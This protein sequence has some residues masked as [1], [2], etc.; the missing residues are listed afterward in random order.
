MEEDDIAGNAKM[1]TYRDFVLNSTGYQW[2]IESL[3]KQVSLE[4]GF[5][6]LTNASSSRPIHQSIM[7]RLPSGIISVHQV[8]E[9]HHA[10]FRIQM[11]HEAFHCLEQGP[12]ANLMTLTSTTPNHVQAL[13][14]QDYF[15]QTWS[16]GGLKLA[17]LIQKACCSDYGIIHTGM[18]LTFQDKEHSL[19]FRLMDS[20]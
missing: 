1:V 17:E 7:S 11:P 20:R 9:I 14:V 5:D 19:V 2:F 4:W 12:V 18:S 15:N 3:R 10:K 13:S 16:S 6:S 8:P